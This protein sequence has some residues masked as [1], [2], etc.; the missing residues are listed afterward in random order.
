METW[1]GGS[2][3][4]LLHATRGVSLT[5]APSAHDLPAMTRNELIEKFVP[6]PLFTKITLVIYSL[7]V[8]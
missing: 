3:T 4:R 5:I 1:D 8:E 7:S 6:A 2:G